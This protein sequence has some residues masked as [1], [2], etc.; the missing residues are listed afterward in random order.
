MIKHIVFF[1]FPSRVEESSKMIKEALE[2]LESKLDMIK[3]LE[4]GVNFTQSERAYDLVLITEFE[5]K[6]DLKHYAGHP[7]HLEVVEQ[8]R[9]L[10]TDT[11]VV[12]YEF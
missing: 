12:D 8:I 3:Y 2:S 6:E 11:K 7:I 1:K 10:G 9:E 5:S 4:V